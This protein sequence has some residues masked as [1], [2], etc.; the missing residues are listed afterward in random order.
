MK[1]INRI[2][3]K[4]LASNWLPLLGVVL[5]VLV[6]VSLEA[7]QPWPFKILIDNVVNANV[8]EPGNMLNDYLLRFKPEIL[9]FIA[10]FVYFASTSIFSVVEYIHS[11]TA[12]KVIRKITAD[13][14]RTAFANL[15]SIA[16]GYFNKQ[17]IGDFI[18]RL[19]YDVSALGELLEEG[20]IP[21]VTSVLYLLVT[22]V[23][24]FY[25]SV[26]LTLLAFVALPLLTY[27][28]YFFNSRLNR[29][30]VRS[31]SFNSAAFS[32]IEE[33]LTHLKIIQ[34]F[35]QEKRELKKF[36]EKID[37][38]LRTATLVFRLDFLLTL[39]VGIVIAISYSLVI[40][41]GIQSVF[42]GTLTTGLLVVFILYLDNLTYP[43]V[44]IIY[45]ASAVKQSYIKVM[46]MDDFFKKKSHP[47]FSGTQKH[48]TDTTILFDRVTLFGDNGGKILDN[49]SFE[50][51]PGSRTALFGMNGSGKT[52][53]IN[54]LMRFIEKPSTGN[55][56]IGGV[57]LLDYDIQSLRDAITYIPQEITL[58]DD[59]ILNNIAL[60]SNK[61][62]PLAELKTAPKPP[63]APPYLKRP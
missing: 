23:I 49:V 33:A 29:A 59:T 13:F 24:M 15:E 45:A 40:L 10:V 41:Y 34:A 28:L 32:F 43:I 56:Y 16:I 36:G 62:V 3:N 11:I 12:K 60:G 21:I 25:I 19:S 50:I 42:A 31:E 9:G 58:L 2:L 17:Q 14:S 22:S 4:E 48:M 51:K 5:L 39:F 6:K 55:I 7:V 44:S 46:R 47:D 61:K 52:T 63:R 8:V 37:P 38:S 53:T 54:L 35:S 27:G 1:V 20:L 18:Y 26:K 57:N 30:T